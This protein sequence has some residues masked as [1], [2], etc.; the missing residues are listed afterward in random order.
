MTG[1]YWS[2]QRAFTLLQ[3]ER[4]LMSI[5]S[6]DLYIKRMTEGLSN[7]IISSAYLGEL[8]QRAYNVVYNTITRVAPRVLVGS[9]VSS[10]LSATGL[11]RQGVGARIGGGMAINYAISTLLTAGSDIYQK[12]AF[13]AGLMPNAVPQIEGDQLEGTYAGDSLMAFG[14]D[15][16]PGVTLSDRYTDKQLGFTD[17]TWGTRADLADSVSRAL[18]GPSVR[19]RSLVSDDQRADGKSLLLDLGPNTQAWTNEK[20]DGNLVPLAQLDWSLKNGYTFDDHLSN[21]QTFEASMRAELMVSK[22]ASKHHSNECY[23]FIPIYDVY[24]RPDGSTYRRLNVAQTK[25]LAVKFTPKPISLSVS[26]RNGTPILNPNI[27]TH[28]DAA[29]SIRIQYDHK[30]GEFSAAHDTEYTY[31]VVNGSW[32][33]MSYGPDGKQTSSDLVTDLGTLNFLNTHVSKYVDMQTD[34]LPLVKGT[35]DSISFAY[36]APSQKY[37]PLVNR[38]PTSDTVLGGISNFHGMDISDLKAQLTTKLTE[39]GI[40]I[41]PSKYRTNAFHR[42]YDRLVDGEYTEGR[43]VV[44]LGDVIRSTFVAHGII[45]VGEHMVGMHSYGTDLKESRTYVTVMP[46][47]G[48]VLPRKRAPLVT[49]PKGRY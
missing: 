44:R 31:L 23:M 2:P 47:A 40:S 16:E 26:K 13:T 32:R 25:H 39:A 19:G 15:I 49:K 6:T 38:G 48:M 36:D 37:I 42:T 33:K 27:I 18:H 10:L 4:S 41:I 34:E 22:T 20:L 21:A 43:G 24:R 5:R 28:S 30:T 14:Y 17:P 9:T 12:A 7:P 3:F 35:N 8:G 1:N 45:N 46:R 29:A 11:N